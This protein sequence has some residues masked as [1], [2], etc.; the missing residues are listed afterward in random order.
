MKNRFIYFIL[1]FV[2]FSFASCDEELEIWDSET[3]EYSGRYVVEVTD[4]SGA[5]PVVWTEL[6]DGYEIEIFNTAKNLANEV[7][8]YDHGYIFPMQVKAYLS[9]TASSF[10][11]ES[12]TFADLGDNIEAI[13]LPAVPP[14][15]LGETVTEDQSYT[16]VAVVEGKVLPGAATTIGGNVSDSLYMKLRFLSGSITFNSYSVPVELR[17]DPEV[18]EF[19]WEVASMV[20]NP[21]NDETFIISGYRY[22]G[23][24][25]DH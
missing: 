13:S 20:Y 15:G 19:A 8:L 16:R 6:A 2:G 17:A 10:Q 21:D 3:L 24:P 23:Y 7:W 12:L 25:E 18:E 11:S 22:T 4:I 1:V 9:G 5:D 14:A